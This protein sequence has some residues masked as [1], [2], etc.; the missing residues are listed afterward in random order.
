[1]Q[2]V[3]ARGG[4]PIVIADETVPN[5]DLEEVE[6]II[7]VPKTADCLQNILSVIPLQLLAY[8]VANLNGFNVCLGFLIFK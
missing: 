5:S 4:K 8:H 7:R 3:M 2:Q 6:H 1:M